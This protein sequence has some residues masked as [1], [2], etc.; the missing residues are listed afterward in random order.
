MTILLNSTNNVALRL[1]G[2]RKDYRL[3]NNLADQA[4][5]VLGF[6]WLR[7]WRAIQFRIFTALDGID[8][9]INRGEVVGIVG[10]NG[11]GKTTLLKLITGNFSPTAGN[12]EVNGEVL[13]LM[14]TGF[15]FHSEFTGYENIRASLVYNGLTGDDLKRAMAEVINFAELGPFINQPLKSYSSGMRARLQ[16]AA[17]TAIRPEILVVDE[18][19]SAGD[20]YFSSKSAAR[21][22][23]LAN[24]GC[25]LL[26]VSH[27]SQQILQFCKRAV[28]IE[29][30]RIVMDGGSLSVIRAYE[31][32]A[33]RLEYEAKYSDSSGESI[34]ENDWLRSKLLEETLAAHRKT[35][36][37]GEI[38]L[39]RWPGKRGVKIRSVE[40][41]NNRG[42]PAHLFRTGESMTIR[43]TTTLEESGEYPCR[44]VILLFA[45][46]GRVLSR[47]VS[48][49][50]N[51]S[52]AAG[53][54]EVI[55][56]YYPKI[57]YGNGDYVFS[58]A[59]YKELD[60]GHLNKSSYYDL[61]S[62]S[63]RF[64]IK[65]EYPDDQSLVHHP[66]EWLKL[67]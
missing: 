57:L 50:I 65:S 59:I 61:L 2:V 38:G 33:Q 17:A 16:F 19:L 36:R 41:L 47:H 20:S 54:E 4:L 45:S 53:R 23:D 48:E 24:S 12:I 60:L 11:A 8:L 25:T 42:I 56:L 67:Q 5:D 35:E 6:S 10:R 13:A 66:A 18:I 22:R 58:A 21:M 34:L 7:F 44:F 51:V 39:S 40:V 49:Y 43:L 46:D 30:G 52:G 29:R 63:F 64:S 28:W 15:G 27:S 31:E 62:R 14:Q 26:L 3:Y 37:E 1:S 32:Y 55:D 9:E